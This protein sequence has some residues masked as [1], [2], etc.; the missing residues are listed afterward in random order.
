MDDRILHYNS[1][2]ISGPP[3]R[4]DFIA[5]A[6]SG[7]KFE[8]RLAAGIWT[9]SLLPEDEKQSYRTFDSMGCV[10]YSDL[11]IIEMQ[12]NLFMMLGIL[13]T[14]LLMRE[15]GDWFVNGKFNGSDRALAK[16]SG[17]TER[18]NWLNKVAHTVHKT[19]IVPQKAWVN[20]LG[21]G[22]KRE[23]YYAEI[24]QEIQDLG[25]KFLKYFDIDYEW[26]PVNE[27]SIKKH[28]RQAPLQAASPTCPSWHTRGPV[29]DCGK[30]TS[31]HAWTLTGYDDLIHYYDQYPPYDKLMAPNFYISALMKVLLTP[32]SNILKKINPEESMLKLYK[33]KGKSTVY[34]LGEG[35][36]KYHPI[37][38]ESYIKKLYG[39]WGQVEVK[40]LDYIAPEKQGAMIGEFSWFLQAI[41]K[42]FR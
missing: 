26:V 2:L 42:L 17:T 6:V 24:P 13:D 20:D 11:N 16:M 41:S 29:Q 4:T 33:V 37:A 7:L 23:Q 1:G 15:L 28:L 27:A 22:Y 21:E 9:P 34:F 25:L 30:R 5:G 10:S 19:G 12:M 40:E 39:G 3:T 18:G 38:S 32:K 14:E 35:S 8:E 36:G 31:T